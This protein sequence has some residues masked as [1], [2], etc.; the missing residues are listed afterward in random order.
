MKCELIPLIGK[1]FGKLTV[2]AASERHR[3]LKCLCDCG[4]QKEVRKDH[5]VKGTTKTC[6]CSK[7]LPKNIKNLTGQTFGKLTVLVEL[8]ERKN[9]K[10]QWRCK[11]DCGN[12]T[13]VIT[14]Y[15]TSG[16]TK[17]CGCYKKKVEIENLIS[18]Y[19]EK[20]D[21]KG[22]LPFLHKSRLRSD[23]KS[24]HKGVILHK[25]TNKWYAYL[26]VNGL[27]H[28]S[29]LYKYKKDAIAARKRFEDQYLK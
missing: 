11:C 21:E 4:N 26:T 28:R 15:L 25:A 5:L 22:R 18:K 9:G 8:P 14:S 2:V 27:I 10:I 19:E 16:D 17:S 20:R 6:G 1:R 3:Y 23:N 12:Y 24:G 13:T 7:K 29:S